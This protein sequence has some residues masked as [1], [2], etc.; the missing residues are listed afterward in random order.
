M[1]R[2]NKTPIIISIIMLF[3]ATIPEPSSGYYTLLR[4]I[5]C[6]TA[7]YLTWFAKNTNKQG[8]MWTFGFVALLFNPIFPIH[9][10]KELWVI[11]D[12][13]VAVIFLS[14]I[15]IFRGKSGQSSEMI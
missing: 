6:G 14:S 11:I 2:L 4:L 15:F 12:I 5:V 7:I 9:L 8:W 13:T 1:N 3:L 10:E